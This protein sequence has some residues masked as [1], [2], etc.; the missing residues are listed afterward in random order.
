[1][2]ISSTVARRL[3]G[4]ARLASAAFRAARTGS[5]YLPRSPTARREERHGLRLYRKGRAAARPPAAPSSTSTSIRTSTATTSRS[6]RG[7]GPLAAGADHRGAEAEGARRRAVEPVPAGERPRRRADQPGI[8]AAVR[9]HGPRRPG[10][11]RCSTAPR[12][13]PATWRPSSATAPRRRSSAGW[14]R[15]WQARSAPAS[16]DR[17]GRGLVRRHQHPDPHHAATATT[18]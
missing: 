1:M 7:A 13:T 17:A 4:A 8:R 9:D 10:R 3:A 11:P 12:P 15:C 2:R 18:T 6:T 16:H 14:S 5:G